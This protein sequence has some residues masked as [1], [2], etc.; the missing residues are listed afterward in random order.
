[1]IFDGRLGSDTRGPFSCAIP[2]FTRVGHA[3]PRREMIEVRTGAADRFCAPY[4][5]ERGRVI[6][7][8][9]GSPCLHP[10]ATDKGGCTSTG[11]GTPVRICPA[12]FRDERGEQRPRRPPNP[13]RLIAKAAGTA[14][15]IAGGAYGRTAWRLQPLGSKP[16]VE[17]RHASPTFL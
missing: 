7:C 8:W 3:A 1:M 5:D 13:F 11:C 6:R 4:S 15:D 2:A 10:L 16:L 14:D 9:R 17:A 12:L